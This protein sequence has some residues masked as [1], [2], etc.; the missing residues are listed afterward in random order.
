MT[1]ETYFRIIFVLVAIGFAVFIVR[2]LVRGRSRYGGRTADRHSQP[3][4]YWGSVGMRIILLLGLA[5][6]AALPPHWPAYPAIFLGLFGGQLFDMLVSGQFVASPGRIMRRAEDPKTWQRW[7][8]S[9]SVLIVM[10]V[11]I[12]VLDRLSV[13]TP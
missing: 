2:D 11:G 6:G 3:R 8:I 5:V 1:V 10:F 9:Y 7:V 4:S 12:F 13:T